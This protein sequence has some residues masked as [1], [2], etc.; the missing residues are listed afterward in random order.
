ML[1]DGLGLMLLI[2]DILAAL[3]LLFR[4]K[5]L[6]LHLVTQ[7][8]SLHLTSS[9]NDLLTSINLLLMLYFFSTALH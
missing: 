3:P 9:Y 4:K 1:V 6:T 2:V 7:R 8:L 5:S